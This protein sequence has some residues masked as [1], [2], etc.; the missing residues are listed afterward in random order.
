MT[1]T[2]FA[3]CGTCRRQLAIGKQL[4]GRRASCIGVADSKQQRHGDL[5]PS[6][7]PSLGSMHSWMRRW[8]ER[9][10]SNEPR[11]S[12]SNSSS[13]RTGGCAVC[14]LAWSCCLRSPSLLAPLRSSSAAAPRTPPTPPRPADSWRQRNRWP[15]PTHGPLSWS[16]WPLTN[17]SRHQRRSA[18]AG[19]VDAFR[20]QPR[21]SREGHAV[22]RSRLVGQWSRHRCTRDGLESCSNRKRCS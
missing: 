11:L 3:L 7:V 9:R 13:S 15:T 16:P 1:E 5:A 8:L 22:R 4:V 21:R 18:R 2:I 19:G 17:A 20:S 10:P 14:S 12:D 6:T